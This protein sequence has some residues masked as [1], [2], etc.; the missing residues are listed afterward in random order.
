MI[1]VI[2]FR[3]GLDEMKS[4][5]QVP[6]ATKRPTSTK[7]TKGRPPDDE[8]PPPRGEAARKTNGMPIWKAALSDCGMLI[9]SSL[10]EGAGPDLRCTMATSDPHTEDHL[11]AGD[12]PRRLMIDRTSSFWTFGRCR[13]I[14]HKTTPEKHRPETGRASDDHPRKCDDKPA[15][16]KQKHRYPGT[17]RGPVEAA[18]C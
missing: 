15:K 1:G 11:N 7:T 17:T 9:P 10:G 14:A 2:K 3:F 4:R 5:E 8:R 12:S 18:L 13:K 16:K 6:A